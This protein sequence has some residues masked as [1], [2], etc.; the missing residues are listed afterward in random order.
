MSGIMQ[1]GLAGRHPLKGSLHAERPASIWVPIGSRK[2]AARYLNADAMACREAMATY[3]DRN[4]IFIDA[5]GL[6]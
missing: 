6:D 4:R 5:V 2:I 3:A 1:D